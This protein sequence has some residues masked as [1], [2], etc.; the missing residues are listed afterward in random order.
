MLDALEANS[1]VQA[2]YIQNFEA[3]MGDAQ[4]DRLARLL[5]RRRIWALNV[6]ENF[7]TSQAVRGRRH[8]GRGLWA[9][10]AVR[11]SL[12]GVQGRSG[13]RRHARAWCLC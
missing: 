12:S 11:R 6:G 2:L 4:L 13:Q 5:R 9:G 7:G 10:G 1:R 8:T 3:G